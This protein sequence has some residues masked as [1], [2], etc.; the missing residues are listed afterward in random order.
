[1]TNTR[2]LTKEEKDFGKRKYILIIGNKL[3]LK[4]FVGGGEKERQ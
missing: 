2:P 3:Y 4:E 1:M